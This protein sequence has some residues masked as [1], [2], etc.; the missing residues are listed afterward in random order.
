VTGERHLRKALFGSRASTAI[1]VIGSL[2]LAWLAVALLRWGLL[3]AEVTPDVEACRRAGGAC[4]GVLAEKHRLLLVGRYPVG[5]GWRPVAATLVLL[6]SIGVAALPRFFGRRGLALVIAGVAAY[7]VLMKGGILGLEPVGT[8][9]WGGLPL[10]VMLAF[11]SCLGAAPL[12]IALALARRS[13]MTLL[14][15]LAVGFIELIRGVPL[16]TVLFFG[17]F[18]LPLLLPA[19]WRADTMLR[20]GLCLVLFLSAYLAE[21]FRGGLQAIAQGQYEAAQALSLSR[22]QMLRH[23]VL[24]QALRITIPPTTSHFIGAVKDTSL[25]AIVNIYDLTGSLKMAIS[26][27]VWHPF[28]PEMYIVVCA[29][30]LAFGWLISRYGRFLETRFALVTR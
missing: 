16:I 1:T 26:D 27:P 17:V 25:V 29:I 2:L 8:D 14:R 12:G 23:I 4:W 18:V 15:W 5:E 20:I 22:W 24:P 10:T 3:D 7:L 11:V 21:V 30:Y 19:S 13:R 9:L 28:A 6:S